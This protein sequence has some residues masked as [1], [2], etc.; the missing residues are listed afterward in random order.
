MWVKCLAQGYN[1]NNKLAII[2][3][4]AGIKLAT[5]LLPSWFPH[6]HMHMHVHTHAQVHAHTHNMESAYQQG[7]MAMPNIYST[8]HNVVVE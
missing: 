1:S 5:S 4:P 3:I 6:M 2:H 8:K 7:P